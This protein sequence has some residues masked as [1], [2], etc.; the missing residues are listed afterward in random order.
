MRLISKKKCLPCFTTV[1][2]IKCGTN[3]T[4]INRHIIAASLAR[5]TV[6]QR[7]ASSRKFSSS[8]HEVLQ[9]HGSLG[10]AIVLSCSR[11][12]TEAKDHFLKQIGVSQSVGPRV[13]MRLLWELGLEPLSRARVN[14]YKDFDA[15]G[16]MIFVENGMISVHLVNVVDLFYV[17]S[18]CC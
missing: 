5:P 13:G 9:F 16:C 4:A 12:C 7:V 3:R 6:W 17:A 11:C 18:K 10:C 8:W 15:L 14:I 2:K 1:S